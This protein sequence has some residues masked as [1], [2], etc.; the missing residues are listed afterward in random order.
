MSSP[1]GQPVVID[2]LFASSGIEPE[3]TASASTVEVFEGLRVPVASRPHLIAMKVLARDDRS[4]PQD[5]DDLLS[6]I[7]NAQP[8]DIET[9]RRALDLIAERGFA[10]ARDLRG[11]LDAILPSEP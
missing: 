5:Y 8:G 9:A 1:I 6:L 7:R 10:R 3:I 11:A 2:L 4:R